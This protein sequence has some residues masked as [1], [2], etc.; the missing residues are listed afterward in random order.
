MSRTGSYASDTSVGEGVI[1]QSNTVGCVEVTPQVGS[2]LPQAF[3]EV[4]VVYYP[5]GSFRQRGKVLFMFEKSFLVGIHPT[6]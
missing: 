5:P 4:T 6:Q 3:E 1:S 2:H